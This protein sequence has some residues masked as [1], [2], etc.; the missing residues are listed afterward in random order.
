[1]YTARSVSL[2]DKTLERALTRWGKR[3]CPLLQNCGVRAKFSTATIADG[4]LGEEFVPKQMLRN[5]HC[6]P[7]IELINLGHSGPTIFGFMH[8][9]DPTRTKIPSFESAYETVLTDAK[10]ITKQQYSSDLWPLKVKRN[11][12]V[13]N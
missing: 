10:F 8:P 3:T 5:S 13:D 6:F 11:C 12:I 9:S 1:M 4:F 7:K 2:I